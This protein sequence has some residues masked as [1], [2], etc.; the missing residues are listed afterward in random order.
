MNHTILVTVGILAS[1]TA[2]LTASIAINLQTVAA[3]AKDPNGNATDAE[4]SET[5][6]KFKQ[7]DKNN[8]SGFTVCCNSAA[9]GV[10]G[11]AIIIICP[12]E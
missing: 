11:I 5:N 3:Y 12:I 2:A 6:L 4:N 10:N 9:Q 8:C 7:Q 1:I